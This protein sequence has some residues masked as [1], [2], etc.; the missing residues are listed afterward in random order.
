MAPLKNI[1]A[2]PTL[3]TR[4]AASEEDD[5]PPA[6]GPAVESPRL[7]QPARRRIPDEEDPPDDLEINDG[8][9]CGDEKERQAPFEVVPGQIMDEGEGSEG[10]Q[11]QGNIGPDVELE[12]GMVADASDLGQ[13]GRGDGPQPGQGDE[14]HPGRQDPG[15]GLEGEGVLDERESRDLAPELEEERRGPA[16]FR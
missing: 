15:A 3:K 7:R 5:E 1:T 11:E 8:G 12:T 9:E 16:D 4:T 14:E 13:D 10:K 6:P 2:E